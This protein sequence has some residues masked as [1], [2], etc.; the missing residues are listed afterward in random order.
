MQKD[1][2]PY[3]WHIFYCKSRSEKKVAER[4]SGVGI[5]VFLPLV[6]QTKQWSDRKKKVEN[7]LLPG[8]VFAHIPPHK[9]PEILRTDGIVAPLKIGKKYGTLHSE[10]KE[11]LQR[12]VLSGYHVKLVSVDIQIGQKVRVTAGPLSELEGICISK[13][14]LHYFSVRIDSLN[15]TIMARVPGAA[16][17]PVQ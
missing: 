17:Q 13:A 14:G 1:T 16:L 8:Y 3:Q 6:V 5:E 4:L 2:D 7:P 12:F 11:A 10:E 15:H 9:V